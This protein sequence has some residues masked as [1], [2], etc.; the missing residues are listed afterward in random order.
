MAVLFKA[1][2]RLRKIARFSK[3]D[4][5][6]DYKLRYERCPSWR[7][8][9][10]TSLHAKAIRTQ[11]SVS[12]VTMCMSVEAERLLEVTVRRPKRQTVPVGSSVTFRCT[13]HSNVSSRRHSS[14]NWPAVQINY[15]S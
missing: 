8:G 2:K 5:S 1:L 14:F 11:A 15:V 9:G 7:W 3:N 6:R 10:E 4:D 13:G 12:L